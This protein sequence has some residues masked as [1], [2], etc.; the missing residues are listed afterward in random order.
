MPA[1]TWMLL[2]KVLPT[3]APRG[4]YR[5]GRPVQQTVTLSPTWCSILNVKHVLEYFP[6]LMHFHSLRLRTYFPVTRKVE[7]KVLG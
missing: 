3:G 2:V 4:H 5:K 1:F 6:E 7:S